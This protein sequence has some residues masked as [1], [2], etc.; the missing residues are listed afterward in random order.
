MNKYEQ[1]YKLLNQWLKAK[2]YG[3]SAA[4]YFNDL[5]Y[6]NIAIYGMADLA[7]R[8]IDDLLDS[9]IK[10]Q[11]GIDRDAACASAVIDEVYS[12]D[13][14]LPMVD[15]IVVTPFID[16]YNIKSSLEKYGVPIISIEEVVWSI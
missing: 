7:Q 14:C 15:V 3:H 9:D 13:D 8:L 6:K 1:Y 2:M 11:Y 12:P 16:F 4:E 5:G 10:V